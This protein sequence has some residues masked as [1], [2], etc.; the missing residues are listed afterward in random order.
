MINATC[1][2]SDTHKT[3]SVSDFSSSQSG[4]FSLSSTDKAPTEDKAP[5]STDTSPAPISAPEYTPKKKSTTLAGKISK[6]KENLKASVKSTLKKA[7]PLPD[8]ANIPADLSESIKS[9]IDEHSEAPILNSNMGMPIAP[10]TTDSTESMSLAPSIHTIKATAGTSF[11]MSPPSSSDHSIESTDSS[12]SEDNVEDS[13]FESDDDNEESVESTNSSDTPDEGESEA[14]DTEDES[15]STDTNDTKEESSSS[16]E[17]STASTNDESA[18]STESSETP[19]KDESTAFNTEDSSESTDTKSEDKKDSVKDDSK[20]KKS[21]KSVPEKKD[22][23]IKDVPVE[24]TKKRHKILTS[25]CVQ[26]NFT[27]DAI[28]KQVEFLVKKKKSLIIKSDVK[29][30]VPAAKTMYSKGSITSFDITAGKNIKNFSGIKSITV[31]KDKITFKNIR[32]GF[33]LNRPISI[34]QKDGKWVLD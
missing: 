15:E 4:G 3:I 17:S 22:L 13:S 16:E 24:D 32:T 26:N 30:K 9:K 11:S 34:T 28:L 18:E 12:S 29:I 25:V 33:S 20:E 19:D 31:G 6:K 14:S 8:I 21:T 7:I 23:E 5:T 2:S 27:K 10:V 1:L